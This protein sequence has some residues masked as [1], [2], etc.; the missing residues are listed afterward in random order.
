MAKK[1]DDMQ[2]DYNAYMAR[3]D[4]LKGRM[5]AAENQIE[6]LKKEMD[7]A[8]AAGDV[9]TFRMKKAALADR[10]EELY[11]LNRRAVHNP[12]TREDA[13]SAWEDRAKDH[14]RDAK[15]LQKALDKAIDELEQA[16][17]ALLREQSDTLRDRERLAVYANIPK[18][19]AER[20]F[21]MELLQAKAAEAPNYY[22]HV[23]PEIVFLIESGRWTVVPGNI[24]GMFGYMPQ[25]EKAAAAVDIIK[26]HKP[27]KI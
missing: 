7:D 10:E 2:R 16:F 9:E 5:A 21:K 8:A 24:P 13:L 4:E 3:A 11:I 23:A 14:S 17:L 1:I 6:T 12:V 18:E 19:E 15:K 27:A 20:R 22:R 26:N 25:N